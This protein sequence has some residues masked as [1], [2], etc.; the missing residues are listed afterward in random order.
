MAR[1]RGIKPGF[2]LNEQLAS[3][4]LIAR[5]I[6]PGLWMLADRAGRLE[7]RPL[8]IK[9]AILP[10]DNADVG[11]LLDELQ[12]AGMVIRYEA[13]RSKYIQIINFEKH[14][15]PHVKEAK[16]T[17][18]APDISQERIDQTPDKYS[19]STIQTPD[20][21]SVSTGVATLT[22]SSLT[23]SSLTPDPR[24]QTLKTHTPSLNPIANPDGLSHPEKTRG[25]DYPDSFLKFWEAYPKKVGKDAAFRAWKKIKRPVETVDAILEALRW[26]NDLSQWRQNNGRYV[27]NPAT[28][29]NEGRWKDIQPVSAIDQWLA[30]ENL[31]DNTIDGEF[32]HVA[33]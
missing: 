20:K 6:F 8:R 23:P 21:Y 9:A 26:Q 12:Q 16:S 22:P 29:L 10:Y 25:T 31:A 33:D 19:V 13:E 14:Q 4:S 2:Y 32:N 18:P 27:P 5:F 1:A 17:I 3:C 15:N 28:Y 30:E 7:D 11:G 24:L